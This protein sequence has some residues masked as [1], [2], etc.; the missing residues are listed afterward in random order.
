MIRRELV[1]HSQEEPPFHDPDGNFQQVAA[2]AILA[3]AVPEKS[4]T[5]DVVEN[6]PKSSFQSDAFGPRAEVK[7][8]ADAAHTAPT[9]CSR[10]LM[11]RPADQT[12]VNAPLTVI[13]GTKQVQTSLESTTFDPSG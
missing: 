2:A 13:C 9:D 3:P 8:K 5:T 7:E 4:C 12:L 6:C 1:V 10:V 11:L